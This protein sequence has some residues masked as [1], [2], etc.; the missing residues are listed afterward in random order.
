MTMTPDEVV[1]VLREEKGY[2][3]EG[4]H[5]TP[6]TAEALKLAISLIQDY[7]KLRGNCVDKTE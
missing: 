6:R 1:K 3:D 2:A 7:Q 5:G 4:Y